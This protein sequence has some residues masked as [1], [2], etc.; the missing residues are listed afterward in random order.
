MAIDVALV[1]CQEYANVEAALREALEAVNGLAFVKPGMRIGLKVNLV[2]AMAPDTA[3]TVHPGLV[4]ALTRLLREKG[5][6][7]IIGDSPGGLYT[8]PFVRHV[9]E[10]CGM[11]E[12]EAYGAV[13]NQDFSTKEADDPQAL[14]LRHFPYT[15]WLDHVDALIDVC[16]LKTHGMMGLSCAVKNFFGTVPGTV[17][18]EM[19]YKYPKTLDFANML[20]DLYEHFRPSLVVCDAVLGMEGNGPTQGKPRQVGCLL[21]G[22][23]GHL[24]DLVAAG[25][26]GLDP[27]DI[28]TLQAARDRGLVPDSIDQLNLYGDPKAFAVPD[29]VTLP[30]PANVAFHILGTGPLGKLTDQVVSH[31]LTPFPKL[32]AAECVGCGKC[33]SI[34]PAKAIEMENKRPTIHRKRCIHCFCC[35]EFCP[36]GAMQVG[37]T[38]IARLVGR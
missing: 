4:C 13:L 32:H 1:P 29:Y 16:K 25:L 30:P 28:P 37:R 24:V 38:F 9:Y 33:C 26:I 19:H 3:A 27:K 17:K 10:V 11:T 31:I 21:A 7:V 15:A 18:P 5:A 23:N 6:E 14:Q 8:G 34:C 22:R 20:I 35:Q 36:V 12:A 2:A